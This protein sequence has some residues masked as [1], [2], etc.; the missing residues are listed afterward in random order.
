MTQETLTAL[1]PYLFIFI[2]GMI[3]GGLGGIII[4]SS[5]HSSKSQSNHNLR[6]AVSI[7]RGKRDRSLVIQIE[8]RQIATADKLSSRQKA[9]L[10]QA[11]QDLQ[12]WLGMELRPSR[13]LQTAKEL[14]RLREITSAPT[15]GIAE[16]ESIAPVKV[17]VTEIVTG[18]INP[19]AKRKEK[20]PPKSI[21]AQVDEI[22]QKRLADS[23]FH[24]RLIRLTDAPG[25]GVEVIID[26]QKYNGVNEVPDLAAR[27]FI[28]DCVREWENR[29]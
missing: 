29:K 3:L 13:M 18:S 2:I 23:A 12:G 1:A 14:E 7:W 11:I 21:A 19:K 16:S 20:E 4:A 22:L 27:K 25:G 15:P 28:Q 17:D 5:L 6:Q 9:E 26:L 10:M 8:D 24:D